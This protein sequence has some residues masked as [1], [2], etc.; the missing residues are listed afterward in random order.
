MIDARER[1]RRKAQRYRARLRGENVPLQR[2]GK[3]PV[4]NKER[5]EKWFKV[6]STGCWLWTGYKHRFGYGRFKLWPERADRDAHR[7]AYL[8]YKGDIP[9]GVFVLHRCHV[10]SC[11]N[12]DH[13]YLG[14]HEQ[15]M[16]DMKVSGRSCLGARNGAAKLT[17]VEVW[18]I[19]RR[20]LLGEK[21]K[22]LAARFGVSHGHIWR[23]VKALAWR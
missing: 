16:T 22:V 6:D 4:S 8:I 11:V 1:N 18:E 5:F 19:R 12:P 14:T 2:A 7:A 20:A 17:T 3:K 21:L 9:P 10:P 13:L 23:I 15:N